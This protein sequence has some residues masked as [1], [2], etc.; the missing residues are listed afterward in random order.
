[1][2]ILFGSYSDKMVYERHQASK[3]RQKRA[4]VS[5]EKPQASILSN[6]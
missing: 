4:N 3:F 2:A 5:T 6:M 1:M